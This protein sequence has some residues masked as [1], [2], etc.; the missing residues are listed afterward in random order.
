MC[1]D[2]FN[3]INPHWNPACPTTVPVPVPL[4]FPVYCAFVLKNFFFLLLVSMHCAQRC[5]FFL[6]HQARSTFYRLMHNQPRTRAVCVFLLPVWSWCHVQVVLKRHLAS[7]SEL[8][9]WKVNRVPIQTCH[10]L[11]NCGKSHM[12]PKSHAPVW[13]CCGFL[14]RREARQHRCVLQFL[15]APVAPFRDIVKMAHTIVVCVVNVSRSIFW[16]SVN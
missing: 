9:K 12:R 11:I 14:G 3:L 6:P 8:C 5:Y 4:Y 10:T 7:Q 1:W 16:A 15:V 13:G 2:F